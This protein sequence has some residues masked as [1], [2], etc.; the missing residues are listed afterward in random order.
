[1]ALKLKILE[2]TIFKQQPIES[3]Q[4]SKPEDQYRIQK[5]RELDLHSW[6][7][8]D[9][10]PHHIRVALA[11]DRF[12]NKNT[13]YV[14]TNHIQ[15]WDDETVLLPKPSSPGSTQVLY[16]VRSCST[17]VVRG[18]DQQ[19]IDEIN[20][21]S[22]NILVSFEG[23]NVRLGNAVWP[24]LQPGAKSALERAIRDR[25]VPM[26]VNSCYRTIAQQL[27]LFNHYRAGGRCGI[28]LAARPPKSNHQ[29]G[30]AI[31]IEDVMGWKPHL[32]RYGWRWFGPAD[33]P[34]FDYVWGGRDIRNTAVLAFQRVWNRYNPSD[35]ITEDGGYGP[36]TEKRLNRSPIGGFGEVWLGFEIVRLTN[37]YMHGKDVRRIQQALANANFKVEVDGVFGSGTQAVVKLFQK[38]KGLIADGIVGPATLVKL[39]LV[40]LVAPTP[41]PAPSPTP[42]P[43]PAPA[44]SPTPSPAPS[45]AP[46]PT[47]TAVK[48]IIISAAHDLKDPGVVALGTTAAEQMILTRNAL[49][50][51]LQSRGV[52]FLIVPDNLDLKG[53]IS[54]INNRVLPSDV[55]VELS[56]N[57]FNGSIRGSEVFYIDGNE[58]RKKDA[59]LVLEAFLKKV[60]ELRL[61]KP[62][63]RGVKPDT[64]SA[65][66]QL[67]LCREVAASSVIFKLC[68]LDN[69][70]DLKLLQNNRDRFAQGLADGLIQWS[71]QT[72]R[73]GQ[74]I[75]TFQPI[76]IK[77]Q[78]RDHEE[79]G[80]LINGN[81]FIPAD[82]VEGLGVNLAVQSD[83]RQISYGNVLYVKAVDLQQF[84]ISV[85]WD[86]DTKTVLI[87]T[88][89]QTDLDGSE[90]IIWFGNASE[91]DLNNFLTSNNAEAIKQFPN[92]AKIYIEE[93][94]K[95]EVNHDVA[96]CQMCLT[97]NFLRFGEQ[98]K[99]EQNNFGGIGT[100]N[101]EPAGASFPDIRTGVKAHIQHLKA[102]ATT[103]PI[104][105]PP[106]VSPRF[107]F[108][109]R[110][111]APSVFDL[112][113]RWSPDPEYGNKI[114]ALV[115]RLNGVVSNVEETSQAFFTRLT[116]TAVAT[117]SNG[118]STQCAL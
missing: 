111:I 58:E 65:Q 73:P 7:P 74:P 83:I 92:L 33:Y 28:Q 39:G 70:D 55:V 98:L 27:I 57:A 53:T 38:A 6:D 20:L 15:I 18:L 49:V 45:P 63:S 26:I 67:P 81:S 5:G 9:G 32:E 107:Q 112:S 91:K 19:V 93:A 13:W 46:S 24:F 102:Y 68:F 25:G 88:A 82:L 103:A 60:P 72:A 36:S 59:Q 31:D 95:E 110:G 78:N 42:S 85:G 44:P 30:L 113:R 54:W 94:E 100:V 48:R 79:K 66:N 104:E 87:S 118:A 1:M 41:A 17:H 43:A 101:N 76:N 51:E 10:Q 71:G 84:N 116:R 105:H 77:L 90:K 47:P 3:S 97:T 4:L 114:M 86:N 62:L 34:H 11:K 21:V 16:D 52:E 56:G 50:K 75:T 23:L 109:T 8:N 69:P 35:R 117:D 108:V 99:P 61:G 106:I 96:F 12:N 14:F 29:S 64:L 37:P 22:G 2:D 40:G 115:L 80:L 89:S